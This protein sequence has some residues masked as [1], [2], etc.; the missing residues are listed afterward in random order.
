MLKLYQYG[1]MIG[2][3]L[4]TD[5]VMIVGFSEIEN[6][7]GKV[8]NISDT[9]DLQEGDRII[10]INDVEIKDI[11]S[12]REEINKSKG[13]ILKITAIDINEKEKTIN[14]NPIHTGANEY[15][16]GLWVKDAATGVGTISFYD[17]TTG[18]FAALGHGI[19]DN[20]TGNLIQ[21]DYGEITDSQ[22]LSVTKGTPG[23]PGEVRGTINN[24]IIGKI[25]KNTE[26]GLYGTITNSELLDENSEAI[27]IGSRNEICEGKASILSSIYG[28]EVKEYEIEI[29]RIYLNNNEDNK[30]FVIK[31]TDKELLNETG[32]I[33]RGL[34]RK[35]YFTRT[36][37]L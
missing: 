25:D 3:K 7:E 16:L 35:S 32:G 2:L 18:K 33:I 22:I 15:K 1:K 21:I 14:V 6:I 28:E 11:D 10:K 4:Y 5:G 12:L 24:E 36:E 8:L 31:V 37:S 34:S 26:F 19:T 30:S 27:E 17:P 23:T 13:S 9:N 29:K 20:D